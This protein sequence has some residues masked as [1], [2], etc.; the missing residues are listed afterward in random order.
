MEESYNRHYVRIRDDGVITDAWSDGP[1]WRKDISNAIC[2][3]EKGSYH[4]RLTP[5]GEDNPPLLDDDGVWLYKW[6]DSKIVPRT[7]TEMDQDRKDIVDTQPPS[8]IE[9]LRADV[10]YLS[11]MTG[12]KL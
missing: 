9:Q 8:K 3:N 10:D 11:I 4:F 5:D 7:E 2:V 1:N 6:D 12:V